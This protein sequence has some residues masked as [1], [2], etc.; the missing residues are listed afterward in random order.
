MSCISK[1]DAVFNGRLQPSQQLRP[2]LRN[3]NELMRVIIVARDPVMDH[4][5]LR[6][7]FWKFMQCEGTL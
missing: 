3:V 4:R 5:D 7:S 6:S 2:A 1:I